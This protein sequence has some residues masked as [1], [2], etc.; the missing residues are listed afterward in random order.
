LLLL[1]ILT[2]FVVVNAEQDEENVLLFVKQSS[3]CCDSTRLRKSP[4]EKRFH[5]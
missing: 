3:R 4:G 2:Q 5:R 1:N